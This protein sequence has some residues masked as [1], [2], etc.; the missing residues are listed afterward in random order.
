EAE[1]GE[2]LVGAAIEEHVVIG[3]VEMAVIIDPLGLDLHDGRFKGGG[4]VHV[5]YRLFPKS[6]TMPG[7]LDRVQPYQ[8]C[9]GVQEPSQGLACQNDGETNMGGVASITEAGDRSRAIDRIRQVLGER[10]STAAAV[11][12]QHGHDQTWNEAALPDAVAFVESTEEVQAI[13]K[14]CAE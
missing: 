11:R 10:L 1:Q 9:A 12:E 7:E 14:I 4:N 13:V 8:T 2:G 3:H 6:L 5:Y